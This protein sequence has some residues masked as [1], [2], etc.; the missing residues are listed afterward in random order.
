MKKWKSSKI[1]K[2][3]QAIYQKLKQIGTKRSYQDCICPQILMTHKDLEILKLERKFPLKDQMKLK[4]VPWFQ[5]LI[6]YKANLTLT[7]GNLEIIHSNHLRNRK[8]LI[9]R[10]L[11]LKLSH[12]YKSR[13]ILSREVLAIT[14]VKVQ[15]IKMTI[16]N[17]SSRISDKRWI[18]ILFKISI[19]WLKIAIR[20]M[21]LR[22]LKNN[23]TNQV[24]PFLKRGQAARLLKFLVH[25]T[26]KSN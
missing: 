13:S 19:A 1:N 24:H 21:I 25:P 14:L 22:M 26:N 6:K 23:I 20:W 8:T 18:K 16:L 9:P 15:I 11:K 3:I 17:K 4:V 5:N 12:L 10:I 7:K 2:S